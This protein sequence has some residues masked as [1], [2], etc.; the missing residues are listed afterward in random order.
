MPLDPDIAMLVIEFDANLSHAETIVHGLTREQF[1]WRPQPGRWS[2]GECIA[3]LNAAN[4][5]NLP[6][7]E[8]GIAKG[9]ARGLKGQGPFRYGF[10]M[11]KFTA[12]QEPPVK[13][14][15][16][17]PKSMVPPSHVD[18][19]ETFNE[20]KRVSSELKRLTKEADGLHLGKVKLR[21]P[22]LPTLPRAIV[23]V[24]LGGWLGFITTHDRRHLWQAE[25]VRN[26]PFF[27]KA[28]P[29]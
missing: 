18:P 5:I 24:P 26:D 13:K 2:I 25:Q 28:L 17:A 27:P 29:R 11:R 8:E 12:S 9:R 20:Y 14:K 15:H 19:D 22:G 21:L 23:R 7:I 3:H 4:G 6:E 16:K 1:Q 10:L